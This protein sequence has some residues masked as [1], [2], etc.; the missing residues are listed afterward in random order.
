MSGES[1]GVS[2]K[3]VIGPGNSAEKVSE[4]TAVAP[5]KTSEGSGRTVDYGDMT[6]SPPVVTGVGPVA[7]KAVLTTNGAAIVT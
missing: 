2:D 5:F 7:P 3:T 4:T 6:V 1:S